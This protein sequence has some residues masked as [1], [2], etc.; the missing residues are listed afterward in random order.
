MI[1][2]VYITLKHLL[3]NAAFSLDRLPESK[4]HKDPKNQNPGEGFQSDEG[5]KV[6]PKIIFN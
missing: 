3:P 6:I 5:I 2:L 1:Y 4:K